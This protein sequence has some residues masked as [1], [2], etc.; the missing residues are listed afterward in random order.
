MHLDT[1]YRIRALVK[2]GGT[3]EHVRG[4]T[5]FLNR[6]RFAAKKPLAQVAQQNGEPGILGKS[7]GVQY[8]PQSPLLVL[9]AGGRLHVVR[10]QFA[11]IAPQSPPPRYG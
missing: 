11:S 4:N 2:I 7:S 3:S 1:Y 9:F 10:W 6:I 8:N 5:V